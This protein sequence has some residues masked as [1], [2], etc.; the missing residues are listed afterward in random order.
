MARFSQRRLAAAL[1]VMP[2]S[3]WLIS[4]AMD[5]DS[6]FITCRCAV[7]ANSARERR[8]S[9]SIWARVWLSSARRV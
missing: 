9:A 2:S 5:A 7:R 1:E 6:S 4:W 3:G 8:N